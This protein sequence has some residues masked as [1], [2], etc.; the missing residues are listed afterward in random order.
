MEVLIFK[1]ILSVFFVVAASIVTVSVRM[2]KTNMHRITATHLAEELYEWLRSEKEANWGGGTFAGGVSSFTERVTQMPPGFCF[3][4]G[5]LSWPASPGWQSDCT[6]SLFPNVNDLGYRR[7]ATFSAT[8]VGSY[9][10]Q[11][12][13]AVSVEWTESGQSFAVP[14]NGVFSIWEQ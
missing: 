8:T 13:V 6:F 9:V 14:I 1:S 4:M 10:N 12:N 3:N 5:S 11:V 7:Y 2:T